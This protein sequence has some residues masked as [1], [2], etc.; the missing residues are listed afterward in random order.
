MAARG[1]PRQG[2]G[3]ERTASPAKGSVGLRAGSK[4]AHVSLKPVAGV[5]IPRDRREDARTA[6][7]SILVSAL[8]VLLLLLFLK[9][10]LHVLLDEAFRA[11]GELVTLVSTAVTAAR[12][13]PAATPSAA[14]AGLPAGTAAVA[15][16]PA[17]AV[18]AVQPPGARAPTTPQPTQA[19]APGAVP[20]PPDAS[21]QPV[22]TS[23]SSPS[24]PAVPTSPSTAAPSSG[25]GA[26]D[27]PG[28]TPG[29]PGGAIQAP[30]TPSP[31]PAPA[32]APTAAPT[33]APTA[34]PTPLST[35]P[36]TPAPTAPP[37]PTPTPT[38]AP[39]PAP[40]APPT[41]M[42][43]PTLAPTPVPT[44]A[45]LTELV[46][47]RGF[48]SGAFAWSLWPQASIDTD[49]ANAHTGTS[50]LKLVATAAWQSA[51]QVIPVVAGQT[52][53]VSG[54]A[55]S[56]TKN[57]A[58][59]TLIS[60]GANDVDLGHTDFI[61]P[62]TGSWVQRSGTYVP[63]AGTVAVWLGVQSSVSGT[64]WFDDLSLIRQ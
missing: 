16:T 24:T 23:P 43:T 14:T 17:G 3:R 28:P 38:P 21:Q 56:T 22:S 60:V 58:Y 18:F 42:P 9:M 13:D 19:A 54:W 52:Y 34:A 8:I 33:P 31:V 45:P 41:P 62:A 4:Y 48:E 20:R 47:N 6:F 63:P 35:A 53:A 50:Y 10:P 61:F 29:A 36:P 26:A 15:A 7:R 39:T 30:A 46:M 2:D 44:P 32:P 12:T 64:F 55:R 40:T 27:G 51:A 5:G 59:L 25:G 49:P 57:G 1:A 37:T 11:P